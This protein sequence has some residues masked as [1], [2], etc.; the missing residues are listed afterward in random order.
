[1]NYFL[2]ADIGGTKLATA[3]F[4]ENGILIMSHEI[5]S[6]KEDGEKL[7]YS[8]VESFEKLCIDSEISSKEI[9]ALAVGLPGIVESELGIAI[10]QNNLPWRNFPLKKKLT[11]VFPNTT[12]MI[13]ND[14]YMAT[15]GE[16]VER[17][18][19]TGTF[20]Y[21][22]LST[23]IS[24]CTI[25]GGQYMRGT[26]MAG[27]IGFALTNADGL[28]LEK[29][30]SGLGAEHKGS[31]AFNNPDITFKE[32][33]D[34]YYEGDDRAVSIVSEVVSALAKEIQHILLF[35]DPTTLVLGGGIFNKHPLLVTAVRKEVA[36]Y[37]TH[38]LFNEK[39]KCI[40]ESKFKGEAG[41]RGA[42]ARCIQ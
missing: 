24:C 11:E 38:P 14:V 29:S 37:F 17:G 33:M 39:E 7:F 8:L 12:I 18:S 4:D 42:L 6:E 22:T 15:W 9:S 1:M 27:E 2:T 40:Q 30:V 19:G 5:P 28:T 25:N 23:G 36:S 10:Y 16:Y 41:L 21:L 34:Y 31:I 13:D 26:G 35:A 32:I 3:L 20:V